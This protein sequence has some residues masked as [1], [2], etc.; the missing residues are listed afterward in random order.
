MFLYQKRFCFIC[1]IAV[2]YLLLLFRMKAASQ[3]IFILNEEGLIFMEPGIYYNNEHTPYE[4]CNANEN[5]GVLTYVAPS[6]RGVFCVPDHITKL[7]D[8][9]F[10]DV[11]NGPSQIEQVLFSNDSH[12]MS[13]GEDAFMKCENLISVS[14]PPGVKEI[15]K[16][17]FAFCS[18]LK[19]INIPANVK[20]IEYAC[21]YECRSLNELTLPASVVCIKEAAFNGCGNLVLT[22][23]NSKIV[24]EKNA[25]EGVK[26][27]HLFN[28]EGD[29]CDADRKP[30]EADDEYKC[31]KCG[32]FLK[33][34]LDRDVKNGI[35][36]A[37][38]IQGRNL[39]IAGQYSEASA[40]FEKAAKKDHPEAQY[41]LG[42]LYLRDKKYRKALTMFEKAMKNGH[43]KAYEQVQKFDNDALRAFEVGQE[44]AGE[45]LSKA[46][47]WYKIASD[48]K[49]SGAQY[50]LGVLYCKAGK[51]YTEAL[52]LFKNAAAQGH[53]EAKECL[54]KFE[55]SAQLQYEI[56]R[57][58]AQKDLSKAED[59]FK[60]AAEQNH[61]NSQ[62]ELGRLYYNAGKYL[63]AVQ[64]FEKADKADNTNAKKFL[65][66]IFKDKDFLFALAAQYCEGKEFEKA[67]Q[68]FEQA[69]SWGS[70]KA[71][72]ELSRLYREGIL[73]DKTACIKIWEH[74]N[75]ACS[76]GYADAKSLQRK[77]CEDVKFLCRLADEYS[78]IG[79]YKDAEI[80]YL[81]AS[82]LGSCI[83]SYKLG[84]L[85][86]NGKLDKG[87]LNNCEALACFKKAAKQEAK[88]SE[89]QKAKES[90][91]NQIYNLENKDA[92][93]QYLIGAGF[94]AQE[95]WDEAESWFDKSARGNYHKAQHKLGKLYAEKKHKYPEAYSYF[96][97]AMES[98]E[99]VID[100]EEKKSFIKAVQ[101]D[102][103]NLKNNDESCFRIAED[104][105]AK[106]KFTEAAELYNLLEGRGKGNAEIWYKLGL[107]YL[108]NE[109]LDK[110]R[111]YLK[112]AANGG[113]EQ[114]SEEYKKIKKGKGCIFAAIAMI[115][116]VLSFVL[117]CGD[118]GSHISAEKADEE[119]KMGQVSYE[120][121]NYQ[122][123]ARHF[124][125]VLQVRNP[126]KYS[127][128]ADSCNKLGEMYK[129]GKG[130]LEQ[131]SYKAYEKYQL[132]AKL[133][134]SFAKTESGKINI[135]A[136]EFLYHKAEV[137][138]GTYPDKAL[139]HYKAAYEAGYKDAGYKMFKLASELANNNNAEAQ[140]VLGLQSEYEGNCAA[141]F[142]WYKKAAEQN[143]AEA[144]W[145]LAKCYDEGKGVDRNLDEAEKWYAKAKE[146]G[147]YK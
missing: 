62:Y 55:Q 85:F 47:E 45:D 10:Y 122:D 133:G 32:T 20:R 126:Q 117:F 42:I 33:E 75:S 44:Y 132:A 35:P 54:N 39:N 24:V 88:D 52:S 16:W 92:V 104:S 114:A 145:H 87:I 111:E 64:Q 138:K 137:I 69:A 66:T 119:Y 127:K 131:N 116:V 143:H 43:L 98:A 48:L 19:S 102:I 67:K 120:G 78:E 99:T 76:G 31:K 37:L 72:Y 109:N 136:P 80:H 5:T 82:D 60:K 36:Q 108:Q 100:G 7:G 74:C 123:A 23:K 94:E 56:G 139:A 144:C 140:Y 146:N 70:A 11:K 58:F 101:H 15:D 50:A 107:Y 57:E 9:C 115:I 73:A 29:I 8:Q 128:Y 77:L 125:Q 147:Y 91:Q 46:E 134:N 38:Y 61:P 34:R 130:G 79:K 124:E 83:A 135:K 21:F 110:A 28:A 89:D 51:N 14:L 71:E 6:H 81:K 90:A 93:R 113:H 26:C 22:I 59:W 12:L 142:D 96:L 103:D 129:E 25:F 118:G 18:S 53:K 68:H 112:K 17:A 95:K 63:E 97:K 13:I 2:F 105:F 27:V 86:Y 30:L 121:G 49:H 65:K 84:V 41:E 40:L 1:G 141:A 106:Q 4:M 3:R